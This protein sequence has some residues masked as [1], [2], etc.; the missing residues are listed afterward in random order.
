MRI[1]VVED[2]ESLRRLCGRLL[3]EGGYEVLSAADGLAALKLM[4]ERG[5]PVDLLLT[6]VVM[7]G[8]SGREL[9]KEL[10]RRNRVCRVLYM[11][12]YTDD[13]IV[14]HGVLE[15]GIAFIYKPYAADALLLKLRQ[16]LDGP[17]DQAKA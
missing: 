16:V 3:R 10:A 4:E 17:P 2:E 11:S 8:M 7:P 13:A 15:P 5:E 14:K 1:L 6:D 9:A 12:G